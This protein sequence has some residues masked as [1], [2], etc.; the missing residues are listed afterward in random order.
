MSQRNPTD[1]EANDYAVSWLLKNCESTAFRAAF[2]D[3]NA[4]PTTINSKASLFHKLGKIRERIEELEAVAKKNHEKEF[5]FTAEGIEDM[6]MRAARIGMRK[7][8][9]KYNDELP[10]NLNAS[11]SALQEINH[12]RGHHAKTRSELS[13][14]DN[15]IPV[16]EY[17]IIEDPNRSA[18]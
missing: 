12:M 11:V 13:F 8:K 17:H 14:E 5:A 4:K 6:L 1:Q 9:D 15:E 10:I 2:P 16:L 3:T 7:K 18:D